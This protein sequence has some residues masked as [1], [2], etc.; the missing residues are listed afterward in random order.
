MSKLNYRTLSAIFVLLAIF[1]FISGCLP[2]DP[3]KTGS[4]PRARGCEWQP[5]CYVRKKVSIKAQNC[6]LPDLSEKLNVLQ[7]VDTALWNN[8]QTKRSWASARAA[9]FNLDMAKSTLYPAINLQ[10]VFIATNQNFG[11]NANNSSVVSGGS[12]IGFGGSGG[13]TGVFDILET[14]LMVTYLVWDF[15]GRE[16]TID[17]ARQ[18]LY[19][20]D[21][22][23]NWALQTVIHDVLNA[24][25]GYITARAMYVASLSNLEDAKVT[26]EAAEQMLFAG[27][28]TI[29]DVLQAKAN[30]SGVVVKVEQAFGNMK[31]SMGKLARE[32]G[33]K[34]DVELDVEL[35][36]EELPIDRVRGD[37][38]CLMTTAKEN[39]PDLSEMQALLLQ[40]EA[41]LRVAISE[42][43][44]TLS[45]GFQAE[46]FH[47]FNNCI[48]QGNV[49]STGFLLN[50][51]IFQGFYNINQIRRAKAEIQV[52]YADMLNKEEDIFL[53]VLVAYYDFQTAIET[54]KHSEDYLMYSSQNYDVAKANY[55]QGTGS[56]IDLLNA[57]E[58][59][60]DARAQKI[61][62]R[63]QW[64]TSLANIAYSTGNIGRSNL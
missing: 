19:A 21:W 57:M 17:A 59:L 46:N 25:Y 2:R 48:P 23:H 5:A 44:P 38:E 43:L 56:I 14:N 60:A 64:L 63:S 16:G 54:V 61:Q 39:R 15:G 55:K 53:E 22:K 37:I 41:Q 33:L 10:E 52:A 50:V 13:G 26:L 24:Y 6:P 47:Y 51:P 30:Y 27:V 36:P 3:S 34:A 12:S 7:L 40:K 28:K 4:A 58:T 42:S 31:T 8:P 1:P 11:P 29:A 35:V 9:A 45:T 49:Y 32:L 20:A 18:L 62:S